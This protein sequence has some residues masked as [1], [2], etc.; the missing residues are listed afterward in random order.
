MSAYWLELQE[1]PTSSLG[2]CEMNYSKVFEES[3]HDNCRNYKSHRLHVGNVSSREALWWDAI[4]FPGEGWTA[5]SDIDGT[6]YSA[7]WA[8]HVST[9]SPLAT[10]MSRSTSC[11]ASENDLML[12]PLSAKEAI[13]CLANYCASHAIHDQCIA[14][15]STTLFIPWKN[16]RQMPLCPPLPTSCESFPS[17]NVDT[18]PTVRAI[19]EEYQHL[20]YYMTISCNIWGMK[21]VLHSAFY[22]RKVTCDLVS[23]WMWPIFKI[24][25]MAMRTIT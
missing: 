15:L 11:R 25:D 20:P 9:Q 24:L 8:A 19:L 21:A 16:E 2:L 23:S 13:T 4:L 6:V 1:S 17:Q 12:I 7:P 22:D 5:T 18:L 10:Q 14:A 3:I